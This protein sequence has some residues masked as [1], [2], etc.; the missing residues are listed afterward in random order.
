MGNTSSKNKDKKLRL[1]K[2]EFNIYSDKV[3]KQ[4][5]KLNINEICGVMLSVNMIND[6]IEKSIESDYPIDDGKANAILVRK[7]LAI[8][9]KD[10]S[11]EDCKIAYQVS[12]VDELYQLVCLIQEENYKIYV[13]KRLLNT[14]RE[15]FINK[16]LQE[17]KRLKIKLRV[18]N[19][20]ITSLMN[21]SLPY[22]HLHVVRDNIKDEIYN[23]RKK[24]EKNRNTIECLSQN[25]KVHKIVK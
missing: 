6:M 15:Y 20:E 5:D 13:D 24:I 25:F 7:K 14:C 11:K 4:I 10:L 23:V 3:R 16:H 12:K 18:T 1:L 2:K 21:Q 19:Q 9:E 22:N 17:Y 8:I